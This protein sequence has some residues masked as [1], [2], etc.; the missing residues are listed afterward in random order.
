MIGFSLTFFP[1]SANNLKKMAL[2]TSTFPPTQLC[3]NCQRGFVNQEFV[4]QK[5][6]AFYGLVLL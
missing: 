5:N 6:Q 4:P 2:L 1:L 3:Q